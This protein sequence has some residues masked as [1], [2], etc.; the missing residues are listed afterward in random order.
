MGNTLE[1]DLSSS[2]AAVCVSRLDSVTFIV[3]VSQWKHLGVST[4]WYLLLL[5]GEW[6]FSEN[7][8]KMILNFILLLLKIQT[9]VVLSE[10]LGTKRGTRE[11]GK[12]RKL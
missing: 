2:S 12:K 3:V 10:S 6:E 11:R 9:P 5:Q 8:L 4:L 7:F 1:T